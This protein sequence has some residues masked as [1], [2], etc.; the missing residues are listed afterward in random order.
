MLP[1]PEV[2]VAVE[3]GEKRWTVPRRLIFLLLAA[4]L[5]ALAAA[6]LPARLRPA[7]MPALATRGAA[8]T[9]LDVDGAP[10]PRSQFGMAADTAGNVYVY[11]GSG[12]GGV[13]LG[14]AW[15]FRP[16]DR[17][18]RPIANGVVPPLIEPHLATDAAGN[19]YEF[20]G[21]GNAAGGHYSYD[22]H[23]YGLYEYSP[24]SGAWSDLTPQDITPGA[25]WPL[26]REDFGFAR[27]PLT[28]RLYVFAGEGPTDAPLNDL[29]TYDL[30]RH[31]WSEVGQ[32]YSAP[33]GATI[34]PREIYNISYDYHGGFYLFGGSYL[35]AAKGAA[36]PPL[37]ANDLWHFD[38]ASQTWT[39]LGGKANG[40][41]PA[42]PL[43]RH[44]YGQSC[45]QDGNFYLLDGYVSDATVP[46]YFGG[47]RQ[48]AH[49]GAVGFD[50]KDGSAVGAYA[51]EDFWRYTAREGSWLDLSNTLGD[52]ANKP[53]IP[54][55]MVTD[56]YGGQLVTFGGWH[57]AGGT[58]RQSSGSWSYPLLARPGPTP[59]GPWLASPARDTPLPS[60]TVAV[61]SRKAVPT[62]SPTPRR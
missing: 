3:R 18:W 39:L 16:G 10:P 52:L 43:P 20:G 12:E 50:G 26:G 9:A 19:V 13:A 23:S 21:I 40:Y 46:P 33:G 15:V 45:D 7:A 29:W 28:G 32:R 56:P 35:F 60:A 5:G 22:G 11:G 14:D 34:D 54:Y 4:A 41:D 37:Y 55:A 38:G 30:A 44:Y 31:R 57:P 49:L 62:P 53:A 6:A 27:D 25:G 59:A 24:A 36:A 2:R 17:T 58:L 48:A 61:A 42:M 47:G 8:W 51:I 1:E